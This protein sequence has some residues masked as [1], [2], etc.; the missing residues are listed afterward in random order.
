MLT[1]KLGDNIINC[2]DGLYNKEQLKKW[3]K[4]RIL[5]CPVC[6]KPYEYCH[7]KIKTPYFRHTDKSECKY[8][9]NEPE[10]DEHL[11]GK[12]DLFEW[13]KIQD[14]VV[15]V[16]LEGWI[17]ETKQRPDI[18]FKKDGK[19][20]VIE[21]QCTPIAS[22]YIERHEL[23]KASGII[24][25]WVCGTDKYLGTR[26][27]LNTL[28]KDSRLYYD[29]KNKLLYQIDD[30]SELDI[31][32]I[33]KISSLRGNLVNQY[34]QKQYKNRTFHV[35]ENEYDYLCGYK[36][37]FYIKDIMNSYICVGTHYPSPTGRPSRKYPYPVKDYRFSRNY[38]YATCYQLSDVKLK[39]INGGNK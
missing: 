1:C 22:E 7:G 21:Y 20:Y 12:R 16:V 19:Q 38:S 23:Y 5:L 8:L 25:I 26:K 35:M 2:Y 28:E 34:R 3:A 17:P 4:K 24:D 37:Y 9:Y 32:A 33:K 13:I 15:D 39:S 30:L 14:G 6:N 27:R 31:K 36:N 29:S 18:M 10:T 11:N